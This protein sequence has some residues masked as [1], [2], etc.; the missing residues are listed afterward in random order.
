MIKQSKTNTKT[1]GKKINQKSTPPPPKKNPTY[2]IKT[3]NQP[4][5]PPHTHRTANLPPPNKSSFQTSPIFMESINHNTRL[6]GLLRDYE[7]TTK[8]C[9]KESTALLTAAVK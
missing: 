6:E 9:Q 1:W 3:T 7:Y 4:T 2:R 5:N 8:L